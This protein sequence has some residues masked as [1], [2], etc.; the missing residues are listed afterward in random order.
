MIFCHKNQ[1]IVWHCDLKINQINTL[2]TKKLKLCNP[3]IVSKI[4][5]HL[6]V[7]N[8]STRYLNIFTGQL[9]AK[10]LERYSKCRVSK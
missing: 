10:P 5:N 9:S 4:G 2:G 1:I 8:N 3:R 7:I 6:K